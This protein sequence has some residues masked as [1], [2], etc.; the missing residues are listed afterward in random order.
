MVFEM[1]YKHHHIKDKIK[2]YHNALQSEISDIVW[3]LCMRTYICLIFIIKH[4]FATG[5]LNVYTVY[6]Y[7]FL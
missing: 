5:T 6:S 4:P 7:E 3:Y 1:E 2:Y